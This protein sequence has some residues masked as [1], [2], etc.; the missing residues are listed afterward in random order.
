VKQW[1]FVGV[2]AGKRPRLGRRRIS[3]RRN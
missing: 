2:S 1:V 3:G